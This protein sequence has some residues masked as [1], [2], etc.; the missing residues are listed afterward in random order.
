MTTDALISA[1]ADVLDR[2]KARG[3]KLVTAESCTGGLIAASFVANAGSSAA[4][5][6]GFV[7]YSN[8]AKVEAIGVDAAIVSKH[9]AVSE[10]TARAMAE[11]ALKHSRADIAVAVT[12]I[13]GPDGGSVGRPVGLVHFAAARAG[14][15][16]LSE[17]HEFGN[18]GRIEVQRAT[19][20]AALALMDRLID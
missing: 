15:A 2:A 4:F 10:E 13:A 19:A 7:T 6:R 16:T 17:R 9:G 3:L 5:E 8:A 18:V 14:R 11:G 1:A 20:A 12:G